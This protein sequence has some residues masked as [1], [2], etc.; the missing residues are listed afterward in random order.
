VK[1]SPQQ[2]AAET[3]GAPPIEQASSETQHSTL[4]E[5][6]NDSRTGDFL[7]SNVNFGEAVSEVMTP[8]SWCVL[9]LVLQEW[10]FLPGR[11][12]VGNI[13]GRPYLNISVFA[14]VL[15]ALGR[16][17]QEILGT[18]A[19]TLYMQLPEKMPIPLIPISKWSLLTALP[20]LLRI[21][22][23]QRQ[24]VRR[25]PTYVAENPAWCNSMRRQIQEAK[26]KADLLALWHE[27][28]HPHLTSTV[29]IVLGSATHANDY[30]MALRWEL[31][32]LVGPD[33]ASVLLSNVSR[34][35]NPVASL[36]PVLGLA[37]MARGAMDRAAYLEQYG[38]RGPHEFELS[39]PRP[40]EDPTWLDQQ[41]AQFHKSPHDAETLLAQQRARFDAAWLNLRTR[42]PRRAKALQRR[43]DVAADCSRM[44]ESARSE[45]VR[46]RWMARLFALRAGQLTGLEDDIFFLTVDEVLDVLA[47]HAVPLNTIR[48]RRI[49]YATYKALPP[50]PPIIL[51]H[52]DPIAWAADPN[53][54]PDLFSTRSLSAIRQ[55]SPRATRHLPLV[56][57]SAGSAGR[58][59]GVVRRLDHPDQGDQLQPGEILVTGQ[60]DIA[61]TPLFLRTAA[62]VTDVGAPLSHAAIVARELGIPAVVGCGDATMRLR[63]GDRVRVDG[64]RGTVELLQ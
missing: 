22:V 59:D 44:R 42:Y 46:D 20:N 53:R 35:A 31:T 21:Q 62:V 32:E 57:G 28:L 6:W 34:G 23:R 51:G 43:I 61:W 8:L 50:Y 17:R 64:G 48:D 40:V 63:T 39:V 4:P 55:P 25:L 14:S 27:K 58:V 38:H 60:T 49:S 7:W 33:D 15:D 29:W 19:G 41:I 36:G 52:F 24:G 10:T 37:K 2:S 45:Y 16:N 26:T 1:Q 9:R 3:P 18:L 30:T 11:E 13:G 47:G 5:E 12:S 56:T 54:R